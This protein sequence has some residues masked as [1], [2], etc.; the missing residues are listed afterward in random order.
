MSPDPEDLGRDGMRRKG[1]LQA[2]MGFTIYNLR[3]PLGVLL[4]AG[5]AG[6]E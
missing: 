6:G 2:G 3:R 4:S 5:P 1:P